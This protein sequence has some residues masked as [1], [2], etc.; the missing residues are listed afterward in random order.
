[1]P[2]ALAVWLLVAPVGGAMAQAIAEQLAACKNEGAGTPTRI[3]A[4]TWMIDKAKDD[5]DILTEAICSA[6]CCTSL[7]ATRRPRSRTT[8]R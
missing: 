8:A 2:L 5:E 4:C 1:M 6:A 7:P 3:D